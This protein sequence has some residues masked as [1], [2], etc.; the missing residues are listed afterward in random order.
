MY[1]IIKTH[2]NCILC[3]K[4]YESLTI[5]LCYID[6]IAQTDW[7]HLD[8]DYEIECAAIVRMKSLKS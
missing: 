6:W 1:Q 5:F 3:P 7:D 2:S 4:I 8:K